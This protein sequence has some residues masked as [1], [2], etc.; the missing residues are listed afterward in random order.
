MDEGKKL[1]L[2][3]FPSSKAE[4]N[5]RNSL[6]NA[7]QKDL[8]LFLSFLFLFQPFGISRQLFKKKRKE[9]NDAIWVK[10]II[11]IVVPIEMQ[12]VLIF[13]SCKRVGICSRKKTPLVCKKSLKI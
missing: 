12:A 5:S 3:S 10:F 1:V 7:P 2:V 13:F 4:Y 8:H 9:K 6:Q 11:L